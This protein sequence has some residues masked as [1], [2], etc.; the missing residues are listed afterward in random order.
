MDYQTRLLKSFK[1]IKNTV[2]LLGGEL[3][4]T[5]EYGKGSDFFF[6]ISQKI[7]NPERAAVIKDNNSGD[8]NQGSVEAN[9][10]PGTST[11]DTVEQNT[12]ENI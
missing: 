8:N 1:D 9:P 2:L 4:L 3:K 12:D 11:G 6:T 5:S 10:N 7:V